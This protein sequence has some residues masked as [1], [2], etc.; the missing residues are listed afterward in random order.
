MQKKVL[1][2]GAGGAG[3]TAALS[4]YD[5]GAEVTI[6]SKE[7]PTRA[8]TSMAQGGINASL[9]NVESDSVEAHIA[10]TLR[11]SHHL[12]KK[13]QV[14]RLCHNA[15][16]AIEWLESI[17]VPFSRTQDAKIAQRKLGGASAARACY[18][19][20]YTGLKIL[21][22]LYDAVLQKGIKIFNERYLL[23]IA[24]TD[25]RAVGVYML[26]IKT[27]EVEFYDADSIILATGGFSTIYNKRS[28]N[29][30]ASTGDGIAVAYKAGAKVSNMEFIQFH[31]TAM[32]NSSV[33][34]SE[35][36]RGAGGYL[37]NSKGE[38]FCNELSS[39]DIVS[40]AIYEQLSMG[41][42]V[43]LDLRHLGKDFLTKEFP[44][45]LKLA[46]LY[47]NVDPLTELIPIKPSAHY[48]MGGVDVD[49]NTQ[50]S[51]QGLFCVGECA[52]HHVHGANRLGGNSLLELIVFAK[53]AG[54]K[55]V[56][57]AQESQHTLRDESY[58]LEYNTQNIEINFYDVMQELGDKLYKSAG[59]LRDA[60][61]LE[62][63]LEDIQTYKKQLPKMGVTDSS[64]V[65][66]TN[67]VEFLE[68]QN[69]LLL[70]ELVAQSA[71]FREESRGAHFRSDMPE[72]SEDFQSVTL[73]QKGRVIV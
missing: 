24:V 45:E 33:L 5:N 58:T 67:V 28:T 1:I 13:E 43:F 61:S 65:Y 49:A 34:I 54:E 59:I 44:Q 53:I 39:R 19:Q 4:A 12:A 63:L 72:E 57:L 48:T 17:G 29:S 23:E 10:D 70:S 47:E 25:Q 32:K 11:S 30:K 36:V 73:V 46:S 37:L 3:L 68:F 55:A 16:D 66:N 18:A 69:M 51:L 42:E 38:R 40:R 21:H 22:T 27:Q 9:G 64:R 41:E 62:T 60:N 7:Y 26:N 56:V 31:P 15:K 8:Q 52:N 71:L 35:G 2:V 6:V 14:E 20:D 50:S